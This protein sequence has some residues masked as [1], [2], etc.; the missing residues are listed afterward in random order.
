MGDDVDDVDAR[1]SIHYKDSD[2]DDDEG[3]V[4]RRYIRSNVQTFRRSKSILVLQGKQ[5]QEKPTQNNL[6]RTTMEGKGSFFHLS[7]QRRRWRLLPSHR[8]R[9]RQR[10]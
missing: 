8:P 5:K 7:N 10:V 2:D 4:M 3:G 6:E 9:Y 1:D